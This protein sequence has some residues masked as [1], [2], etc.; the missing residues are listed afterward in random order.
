MQDAV[1]KD[2]SS[3]TPTMWTPEQKKQAE[4]DVKKI[5][6]IQKRLKDEFRNYIQSFGQE[7]FSNAG[8]GETFDFFLRMDEDGKTMFDKLDS[9]LLSS[10]EKFSA[11]FLAISESAQE[12]FNFISEASQRNFD[13]E[14]ARLEEQRDVAILFAGESTTARE[15]IER[16]YEQRRKQIARREA[17]AKK[18]QAIFNIAI[19]TAQAIV[20]AVMKSPLTSGLPWSAIAAAI[21]AA[22]IAMVSSQQI[23]QYWKG[24]DNAEGG[25][26]WTQE[27]GR[28]IITDSQ[29]RVKSLGSDKGAELTMLS[30]GDK[31]F[32]AE[33]SAMMFDSGLNSIL[34]N[35]GISLP[36]IE[37][38][39]DNKILADKLDNL[40][41]VIANKDS[42]TVVKDARGERI[43]QR[44]QAETKELLNNVLTYK[45]FDV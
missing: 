15:E 20:A 3:K 31:V 14:Y 43:Y 1:P 9:N 27:K 41:S 26:A 24:T 25:L 2:W 32:T 19:D 30:K 21:G 44:K 35:N 8:F 13:A 36:K 17:Q 40:T 34:S 29:G 5:A 12:A 11:T 4:E 28:E 33:K 39:M 38:N 23:P 10:Q 7:F 16:Q 42:F 18:Q 45:G 6:E 37:V 22:Q